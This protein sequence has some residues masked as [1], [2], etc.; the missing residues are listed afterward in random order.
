M[1]H[2]TSRF[3][4]TSPLVYIETTI[5]SGVTIDDY[6]RSRPQG[7]SRRHWLRVRPP[8]ERRC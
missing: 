2:W 1:T 8:A 4:L 7:G 6:R 5:P 3:E